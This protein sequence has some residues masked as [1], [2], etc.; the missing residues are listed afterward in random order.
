MRCRII[1]SNELMYPKSSD[2]GKRYLTFEILRLCVNLRMHCHTQRRGNLH[3]LNAFQPFNGVLLLALKL[4][5]D[6]S[7]ITHLIERSRD[8]SYEK[9]AD[10]ETERKLQERK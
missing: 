3:A 8:R 5:P 9:T 7:T 4:I 1:L 2:D 6:L 10:R